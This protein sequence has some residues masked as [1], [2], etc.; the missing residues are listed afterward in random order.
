MAEIKHLE[1]ETI[2]R[3]H[4]IAQLTR[5]IELYQKEISNNL[6]KIRSMCIHKWIKEDSKKL[7]LYWKSKFQ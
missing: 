4:K 7:Y 2:L 6:K 5:E 1:A 3:Y